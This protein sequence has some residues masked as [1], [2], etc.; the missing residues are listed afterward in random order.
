MGGLLGE[1]GA[2]D[3]R[4]DQLLLSFALVDVAPPYWSLVF[5]GQTEVFACRAARLALVTLLATETAREATYTR[6]MNCQFECF[7]LFYFYFY[8][9][10]FFVHA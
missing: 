9:F 8:Y 1:L 10:Y 6:R 7:Y 3:G 4:L 2:L 5:A